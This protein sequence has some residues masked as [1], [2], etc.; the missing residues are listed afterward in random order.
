ME[1]A[2]S[3]VDLVGNFTFFNKAL[4]QHLGYS[5]EE[6]MGM[7]Y[8]VYTLPEN[9]KRV[10]QAYNQVY[11][12]GKPIKLFAI[13]EIR[14]D[15]RHMVA[16]ISV[17]PMKDETGKIIGFREVSRNITERRGFKTVRKE[18]SNHTGGYGGGVL[19]E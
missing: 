10:F 8:N 16:E 7:N 17:S 14:K 1:E 15:G 5:R 19:R 6:L 4:C 13:E 9:I 11:K 18:I 12:T 2:Y 3:E